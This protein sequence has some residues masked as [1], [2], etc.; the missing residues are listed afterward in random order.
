MGEVAPRQ[1][2]AK[3]SA[4]H[5]ARSVPHLHDLAPPARRRN[6]RRCRRAGRARSMRFS[7]ARSRALLART[8]PRSWR[9]RAQGRASEDMFTMISVDEA[10]ARIVAALRAA[11]RRNASP[12]AQ[13]GRARAGAKM[14]S[15]ARPAARRRC[16]RWTVMRCARRT[17]RGRRDVARHRR[18]AGGASFRGTRRRGRSGAHLHRRRGAGRCRRDRHPGRHA[19]ADGDRVTRQR[20]AATRASTSARGAGFQKRRSRC[21]ARPSPFAARP[22]ADRG[23]RSSRK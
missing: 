8:S 18:G 3:R 16:R 14:R 1:R 6:G 20:G 22:V 15:R 9:A 2:D 12:I 23:G 11:G 13:R 5:A 10:V 19:S 17:C 21:A 4:T 7:P